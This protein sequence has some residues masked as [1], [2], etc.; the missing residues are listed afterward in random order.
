M[1]F[2]RCIASL[3]IICLLAA[4]ANAAEEVRL[5]S[6]DLSL[7]QQGWGPPGVDRS[8]E[9]KPLRIAGQDFTYGYGA[10]A[11]G[12]VRLDLAGGST[13]FTARVGIDDDV[14]D[15]GSV[16]FIIEGDGKELGR[17]PLMRGGMPSH[18]LSVDL[19][20]VRHLALRVTDG[21]DDDRF[22]HADWAEAAFQVSG[23][24]P[25]ILAPPPLP[26]RWQL[27]E[28]STTVWPVAS[29][30]R[31]PHEDFIEQGGRRVGQK[32]WYEISAER[33]LTVK[34]GVVWPSLRIPPFENYCDQTFSFLVKHY[35][36][37]VEPR[38]TVDGKELGALKVS[39][40]K[41]DGTLSFVG[42]ADPL[43]VQRV[44]FPA[45]D[46]YTAVDRWTVTNP[47]KTRVAINIAPL[48][49]SENST[50]GPYGVNIMEVTS[51]APATATL[52]PGKSL[53]FSIYFS[54]RQ[55]DSPAENMAGTDEEKLRR[56]FIDKL[57]SSLIL[58]TPDAMLNRAFTFAKWRVAEAMN[59]TRGGLMLAP[60][61]L[62]YYAAVWCNDNVEYAGPFF[63]F[64]GD[65]AGNEGSLNTYRLFIPL[66]KPDYGHIPWSIVAQG[67]STWGVFDRGDAAMYAYGA[68]R[69][70]LAYGD[71]AVAEELWKGIEW[72]LEYCK[73]KLTPAGV[74][75]S[76]S[77]ELEGRLPTGNANLTTSSL[78]YG[79]LRSATDLARALGKQE[80]A[81]VFDQQ[82][83]ILAKAI[84]T[85]F[86]AN[87]DG[88]ATYRYYDPATVPGEKNPVLRSWICMPLSMGI[89]DRKDGTIEALF[90]KKMWT[91]DGL[92][93]QSGDKVFWDRSTLY[94]LR[95]VFQAGETA[96][97]LDFLG[98]YTRRRL[99]GD[100]VPYAVEAFP[101][102]GQGHLASESGLYC[103][104]F[105]EGMFGILPTGLDRFTCTPRLPDGW[106]S[107]ALRH[108]KAFGGDF[109]LEVARSGAKL[110]VRVLQANRVM[111][112]KLINSGESLVVTIQPKS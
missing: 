54:G 3:I 4:S 28:G 48:A 17:S 97:A 35:G 67:T 95:A 12:E 40:V 26:T 106:P 13:R 45:F 57:N 80:Q 55:V 71:R 88:F 105:T 108:I 16:V 11:P 25:V 30:T 87:V 96:K 49:L 81:K 63:P 36:A 74:V 69:F 100:H 66:M 72:C 73:R 89:S 34:R 19:T 15:R 110:Q 29:E 68:S 112:D 51:D 1:C 103:R 94:A 14:G 60:G 20:G 98:Q 84:E 43:T 92:A 75:A 107:M 47:G 93:S 31:L 9:G 10:H 70:S 62:R 37:E 22:D 32:V 56:Q 64:I 21:G 79:G 44:T 61:N 78:Y 41:L 91:K 76:Q 111:I 27:G 2:P 18:A 104:I 23:K 39:E 6:L 42:T 7:A 53:T 58:E 50:S 5:S 82:A 52:E 24:K 109:D 46:K 77:D 102:G 90:S 83:T 101:E 59:D 85:F 33:V 86:G 38:I 65:A 8:V 99:L